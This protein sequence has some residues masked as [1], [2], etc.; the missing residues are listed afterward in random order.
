M[1]DG[2]GVGDASDASSASDG[3]GG[4][5]TRVPPSPF[6]ISPA[7]FW[8]GR[9]CLVRGDAGLYCWG[10]Y[11]NQD[12][13]F[14]YFQDAGSPQ[15]T[16]PVPVETHAVPD[17]VAQGEFHLCFRY[18][19]AVWCRGNNE[20]G[21]LGLGS[22]GSASD[23]ESQVPGLPAAVVKIVA[24]LDFTCALLDPTIDAGALGNVYCWGDN[25]EGQLAYP[26]DA[27]IGPN[28]PMPL[29]VNLATDA[30][31]APLV[32]AV[33]IAAGYFNVCVV[34]SSGEV[35]CWGRS[36]WHQ[37]GATLGYPSLSYY[38]C[39]ATPVPITVPAG[40][41][42]AQ[43]AI[44]QW[45]ACMR[46]LPS[47]SVYCWG[48]NDQGQLGAG[49]SQPPCNLP[50]DDAGNPANGNLEPGVSACSAIP[51]KV[52]GL[53]NP[54]VSLVAGMELHLRERRRERGVLLG[55]QRVPAARAGS[56]RLLSERELRGRALGPAGPH[57]LRFD[58]DRPVQSVR[59]D[60][61][62]VE[63]LGL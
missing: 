36:D 26:I 57:S 30:G 60:R 21:E 3:E 19:T 34:R 28:S 14:G 8:N 45:H 1:A 47:G 46:T 58:R 35:W 50:L 15:F 49:A 39:S 12:G 63:L 7:L 10:D 44:G 6:T 23:I 5:L 54:I 22:T 2:G 56:D 25:T 43:I 11:V 13:E 20:D 27:G 53:P 41:T 29:A 33:D 51:W 52:P 55:R 40:E 31:V 37:L 24:G 62:R 48:G 42:V 18:G 4:T 32:D 59:A 38:S 17:E 9:L 61:R 16:V